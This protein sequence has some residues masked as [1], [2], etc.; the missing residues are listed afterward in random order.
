MANYGRWSDNPQHVGRGGQTAKI[1]KNGE[2]F[3]TNEKD[4]IETPI[5]GTFEPVGDASIGLSVSIGF[6]APFGRQKYESTVWCTLPTDA[7]RESREAAW[8]EAKSEVFLRLK[9][10]Q[11]EICEAFNIDK[12]AL[13]KSE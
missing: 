4:V 11:E 9:S 6:A 1:E 3:V 7:D 10:L 8:K 12:S 13:L 5:D 2:T